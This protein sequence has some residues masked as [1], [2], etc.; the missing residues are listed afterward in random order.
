MSK[1]TEAQR[2]QFQELETRTALLYVQQENMEKEFLAFLLK[3]RDLRHFVT[4]DYVGLYKAFNS[5]L[6]PPNPADGDVGLCTPRDKFPC[7]Y[8]LGEILR[9]SGVEI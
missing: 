7:E 1:I 8:T 2:V 9:S 5:S 3:H 4:V 6:Q